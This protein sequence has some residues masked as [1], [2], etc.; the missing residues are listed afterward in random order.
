MM[1]KDER[2]DWIIGGKRLARVKKAYS[3]SQISRQREKMAN[4]P[5][6]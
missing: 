6:K 4:P 1:I 5:R 2:N 3:L